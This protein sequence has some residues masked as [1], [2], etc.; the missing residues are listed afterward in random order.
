PSTT[1]SG[2]CSRCRGGGWWRS[3]LPTASAGGSTTSGTPRGTGSGCGSPPRSAPDPDFNRGQLK[4]LVLSVL[5]Q[6]E[7][8]ALPDHPTDD[9]VI[10]LET[11]LV[12]R[13]KALDLT[14]MRKGDPDR[15]HHYDTYR[16]VLDAAWTNDDQ[17]S[18]DEARLLAVLRTHLS[19]SLEE[20]WLISAL[21]K[22]F[23]KAGCALHTPDEV[24]EARKELQRQGVV[25]NYRD[26][27]NQNIDVIPAEVATVVRQ[28]W[29]SQELQAVNYRRLMSHDAILLTDL[30]DVLQRRGLDRSGNKAELIDRVV[31]GTVRPS[32]VLDDLDREK[33][34]G[35]CG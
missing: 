11:G 1:P 9:K 3:R 10:E 2:P 28:E 14:E 32:E 27:D 12:E 22:R 35:M 23:P 6:E 30:R 19:I 16:I 7:T 24:N 4:A 13:S 29:A 33:L 5:L 25:W 20:H 18:P 21:L 17:I 8:H 26:E 34:S 31:G 15:W